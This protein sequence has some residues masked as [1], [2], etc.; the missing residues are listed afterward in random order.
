L[1]FRR[2]GAYRDGFRGLRCLWGQA[3]PLGHIWPGPWGGVNLLAPL[4]NALALP[5]VGLAYVEA[6]LS[7]VGG[8]P[9]AWIAHRLME[10]LIFAANNLPGF[11]DVRLGM[12]EML[13]LYALLL[14]VYALQSRRKVPT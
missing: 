2:F 8:V 6:M 13:G 7:L 10:G 11:L 4:W 5:L 1:C 3:W 9:F 14:G 12:M